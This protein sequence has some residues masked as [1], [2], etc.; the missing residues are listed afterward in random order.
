MS[1][2]TTTILALVLFVFLAV[3]WEDKEVSNKIIGT[4]IPFVVPKGWPKPVYDFKK[5]PVTQ[6][7]FDLGKKL[8]YDGRLS[9]DGNF[10]CGSCHQQF[11]AFATFDHNFSHGVNNS[12]TFRNTPALF[13]LA[14]QKDFMLDGRIHKLELQPIAPI[15]NPS[16]MGENMDSVILK[17]KKD[18]AYKRM[19]TKAFGD[20]AINTPRIMKALTQFLLMLV[21]SN[22]K[23]DKVMRGEEKFILPEQLGYAIFKAKCEV[24]HTEPMFTDYSYRNIGEPADNYMNDFG[25]MRVTGKREDSLKF[26]V[27]S[28]RNV[29]YTSPYGHDGRFFSLLNIFNHYRSKVVDGPT[30]DSILRHKMPLSNYEIGQLTAFLYSLSDTAFIRDKRFAEPGRENAQPLY[31]HVH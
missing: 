1:R 21:S 6:E 11:C 9:K 8:F 3:S 14:W 15:T 22:S 4:P 17:L 29:A 10:P 27:P 31:I 28:L 20:P 13:N 30:T 5:N 19:F 16:E 24:C 26:R 2:L 12:Q 18:T 23:Y 25:R 7:G